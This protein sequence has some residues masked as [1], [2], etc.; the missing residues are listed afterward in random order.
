MVGDKY[1]E[2]ARVCK[3]PSLK[4]SGIVRERMFEDKVIDDCFRNPGSLP[5]NTPAVASSTALRKLRLSICPPF[6]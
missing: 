3:I 5:S 1:R 4:A 6:E 2:L